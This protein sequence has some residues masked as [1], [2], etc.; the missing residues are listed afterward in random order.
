MNQKYI[1]INSNILENS[2]IILI[3]IKILLK[4]WLMKISLIELIQ[5]KMKEAIVN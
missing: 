5:V 2:L 1:K 3:Q 4:T